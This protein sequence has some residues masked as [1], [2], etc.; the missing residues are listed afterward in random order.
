MVF[1]WYWNATMAW[2][3]TIIV[4]IYSVSALC[5]SFRIRN[6]HNSLSDAD[7]NDATWLPSIFL[8]ISL[9]R[10]ILFLSTSSCSRVCG[11]ARRSGRHF[12]FNHR[13]SPFGT[14]KKDEW[15][16]M[17]C[18]EC[19][20]GNA[21]SMVAS[22]TAFAPYISCLSM[23]EPL[24]LSNSALLVKK[25]EIYSTERSLYRIYIFFYQ[26]NNATVRVLAIA[27]YQT[28][29]QHFY[30]I[31][32]L[33]YIYCIFSKSVR[34]DSQL[35]LSFFGTMMLKIISRWLPD[36]NVQQLNLCRIYNSL[37]SSSINT[38]GAVM[39]SRSL[40]QMTSRTQRICRPCRI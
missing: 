12:F 36:R 2:S 22:F 21:I 25:I 9:Y 26:L 31:Y 14:L 13:F 33:S 6:N 29:I 1:W 8:Y 16:A 34:C 24:F 3:S 4:C 5:A 39:M 38:A 37:C 32:I 30:L 10:W 23:L 19:L 17:A 11:F 15:S 27:A 28:F 7:L 40:N 18:I 20:L 35:S